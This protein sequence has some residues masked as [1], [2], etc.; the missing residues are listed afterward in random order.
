[1]YIHP[2]STYASQLTTSDVGWA[3]PG[4]GVVVQANTPHA[5]TKNQ[6]RLWKKDIIFV[7]LLRSF[8]YIIITAGTF[9][10]RIYLK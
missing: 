3:S 7:F 6:N 10:F 1:M 5:V 4:V 8:I 9:I 2:H